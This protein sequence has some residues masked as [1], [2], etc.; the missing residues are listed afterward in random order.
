MQFT[1]RPDSKEHCIPQCNT[2]NFTFHFYWNWIIISRYFI[3]Y[4]QSR[5]YFRLIG[6]F[7][8]THLNGKNIPIYMNSSH[9]VQ[10]L[11]FPATIHLRLYSNTVQSLLHLQRLVKPDK[12]HKP[13]PPKH[14]CTRTRSDHITQEY[15]ELRLS[16]L[17]IWKPKPEVLN[18]QKQVAHL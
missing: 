16:S 5:N 7:F 4:I 8:P 12:F 3:Q 9:R 6:T 17:M 11:H 10:T 1:T 18:S 15:E 2:L 13:P 14:T